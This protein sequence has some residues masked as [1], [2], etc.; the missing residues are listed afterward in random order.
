MIHITEQAKRKL[1]EKIN[2]ESQSIGIKLAVTASGCS[3]YRSQMNFVY[4]TPT[5][6]I[7]ISI[8][9]YTV[10][11]DTVTAHF[12][13]EITLDWIQSQ[14]SEQFIFNNPNEIDRCGCGQSFRIQ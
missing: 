6:C 1:I 12:F 11:L 2:R 4:E 10:F 7:A 9:P 5:D 8:P 14:L 13:E 3:G